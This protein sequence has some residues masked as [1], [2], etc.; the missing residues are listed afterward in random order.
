MTLELQ[1]TLALAA[2]FAGKTRSEAT[3]VGH[4]VR[5]RAETWIGLRACDRL[6]ETGERD[7]GTLRRGSHCVGLLSMREDDWICHKCGRSMSN[8]AVDC[9]LPW[10]V[11]DAY[12]S[13][14]G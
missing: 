2:L 12:D 14:E 1:A 4:V 6:V 10:A 3:S 9:G 5:R 8:D 11:G 13:N 7:T